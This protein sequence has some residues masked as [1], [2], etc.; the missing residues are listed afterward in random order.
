MKGRHV[1]GGQEFRDARGAI[2]VTAPARSVIL[3]T[4]SGHASAELMPGALSMLEELGGAREPTDYFYD[5]WS[6]ATY[7]SAV[8]V[9]FTAFHL[10]HRPLLRSL[11]ACSQSRVVRMGVSVANIALRVIQHHHA[12]PGFDTALDR[13]TRAAPVPL[14]AAR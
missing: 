2:V 6:M 9:D 7:D 3:L 8:R 5:L 14:G 10:R 13:A 11:H 1:E 4:M 12:R